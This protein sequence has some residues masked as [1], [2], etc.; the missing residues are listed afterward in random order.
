MSKNFRELE[1]DIITKKRDPFRPEESEPKSKIDKM[2]GF[3]FSKDSEDIS[4]E[5]IKTISK[6][7]R[8]SLKDME[9]F[10]KKKK[11]V[12]K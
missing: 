4:D 11:N 1:N 8:I 3:K 5:D 12:R 10:R 7:G 9:K 6:A 2:E